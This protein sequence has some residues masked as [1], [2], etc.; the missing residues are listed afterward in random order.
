M[1]WVNL[2]WLMTQPEAV[3]TTE[4]TDSQLPDA[5]PQAVSSESIEPDLE[6]LLFL[7]EWDEAGTT[8]GIE[9]SSFANDN[10]FNLQPDKEPSEHHENDHPDHL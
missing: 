6:L 3:K 7:A 8:H 9:P 10:I 5:T 2:L 4:Q 1:M